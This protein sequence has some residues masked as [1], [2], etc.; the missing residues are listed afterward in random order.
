M[1]KKQIAKFIKD[2]Q[3]KLYLN[4][5]VFSVEFIKDQGNDYSLLATVDGDAV[6]LYVKIN[7]Y[8]EFFKRS[9]KIQEQSLVHELCHAYTLQISQISKDLSNGV[10][11]H[12]HHITDSVESLTQRISY[13]AYYGAQ[14]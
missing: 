7:V 9:L 8:P 1:T 6:Y 4:E 10:I 2:W 12:N 3:H 14:K 13:L 5:W 11:H